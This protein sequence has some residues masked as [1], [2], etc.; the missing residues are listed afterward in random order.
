MQF[1]TGSN[2]AQGADENATRLFVGHAVRVAAVVDPARGVA[3]VQSVDHAVVIDMEIKRVVR[4]LR[5]VR[6]PVLRFLPR[7]HL[8]G[9]LDQGFALGNVG[10]RKHAFAVHAG[11]PNLD[12][13]T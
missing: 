10:H 4:V 1:L 3:A 2:V 6:V 7:D 11:A 5:I 13:T 8:A 12:A 9:V